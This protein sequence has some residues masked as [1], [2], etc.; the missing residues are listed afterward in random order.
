MPSSVRCFLASSER[1]ITR[2]AMRFAT[3]TSALKSTPLVRSPC[4]TLTASSTWF[5]STFS[6]ATRT[7]ASSISMPRISRLPSRAPQIERIPEPQ[8]TSRIFFSSGCSPRYFSIS[9]M[10]SDVVSCVPVPKAIPGSI[11]MTSS[12]SFGVYSSQVGFTTMR[13]VTLV[14]LKNSFHL[15]FQSPSS[16]MFSVTVRLPRSACCP[17]SPAC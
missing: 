6:R 12:S 9:F 2:S 11:S 13:S 16:T 5:S 7:A 10:Q 1:S 8:P 15:S 4:M 17:N 14:G 3:I